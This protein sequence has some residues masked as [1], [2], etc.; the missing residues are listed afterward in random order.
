RGR[1]LGDEGEAA[2]RIRGDDHRNRQALL[3]LLCGGVERL[4]ELH[5]VEAALA[6][7]RTDR[8][9]G[10]SLTG[11]DL[12]LDVTDDFLCHFD[13]PASASAL[14]LLASTVPGQCFHAAS[15]RTFVAAAT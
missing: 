5:D 7:R 8:R 14:R 15:S 3:E 6:Q 11:L 2:V 12:Q 1:G 9:A 4:A 13:S 10:I